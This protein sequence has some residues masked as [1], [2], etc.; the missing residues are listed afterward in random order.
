VSDC[1]AGMGRRQIGD[2]LNWGIVGG[3]EGMNYE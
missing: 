3:V 1:G 2:D